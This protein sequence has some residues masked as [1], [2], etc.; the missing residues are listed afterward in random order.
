MH[1][2]YTY[3][4]VN[5]DVQEENYAAELVDY[6]PKT[7]LFFNE[8]LEAYDKGIIGTVEFRSWM[9]KYDE[10]FEAVRDSDVDDDIRENARRRKELSE[11]NFEAVMRGEQSQEEQPQVD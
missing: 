6:Q 2:D 3:Q 10:N 11:H 7:R 1:S 8:M 4:G 5:M 9:A